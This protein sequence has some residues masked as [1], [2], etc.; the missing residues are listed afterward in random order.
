MKIYIND[1]PFD[2]SPYDD[3][4]SILQRYSLKKG[5]TLPEYLRITDPDIIIKKGE[6]ITIKDVRDEFHWLTLNDLLDAG[7][8]DDIERLYPYLEKKYISIL[9][10]LRKY[11]NISNED[12]K[13]NLSILKKIDELVFFS[14]TE[15][16]RFLR[17][18][19]SYTEK[20]LEEIRNKVKERNEIDLLFSKTNPAPI[21]DFN[22]KEIDVLYVLEIAQGISLE[23]I[24]DIINVSK[25]IPF[26]YLY[27]N[28]VEQGRKEW[29]K[30]YEHFDPPMYMIQPEQS[31]DVNGIYF[32]ILT[33]SKEG[34]EQFNSDCVWYEN[35]NIIISFTLD[36]N[37]KESTIKKIFFDSLGDRLKYK[38]TQEK[39]IGVKGT[40]I[41]EDLSFNRAILADMISNSSIFSYFFFFNENPP[42]SKGKYKTAITKERFMFHYDP[43]QTG[44]SPRALSIVV[45]P[46][47]FEETGEGWI[48][49]R[50]RK[51]LSRHQVEIFQYVFSRLLRIYFN[52]CKTVISEYANILPN[53]RNLFNK[54]SKKSKP[55]SKKIDKKSGKRL[56]ELKTTR[57]G[58]FRPGYASLCQP[59][60][61]QPY[62]LKDKDVESFRKEYGDHKLMEFEDPTT[63]KKDWYACEPREFGEPKK[64]IYPGLRKNTKGSGKYKSEVSFVP[65]CF[66]ED[67]YTKPAAELRRRMEKSIQEDNIEKMESMGE[68]GHILSSNKSVPHGRFGKIPYYLTSIVKNAGYKNVEKGKQSI[69]PIFRY[70]VMDSTSSFLHCMEKAFNPRYSSVDQKGKINIV[71][72][73]REGLSN[74]N[75]AVAAQELFGYSDEN[76]KDILLDENQYI[77]PSYFI[78]LVELKYDCN[79][80]IYKMS[81]EEPCGS[82]VIPRFS[83][84]Y[85]PRDI[86][87]NRRSVFIIKKSTERFH[88]FQ[89]EILVKYETG[90]KR[91]KRFSFV[92]Q[93]DPIVNQAIQVFYEANTISS[94]TPK[95]FSYYSPIQLTGKLFDK[96][97]SQYI[98]DTGKTRMLVY[99]NGLCLMTS[100]L[101]PLDKPIDKNINPVDT[102]TAIDFIES[103]GLCITMQDGDVY[104]KKIQGLWVEPRHTKNIGISYGYIPVI[105]ENALKKTKSNSNLVCSQDT[106]NTYI[107]FTPVFLNDPLRTDDESELQ[108]YRRTRKIAEFLKE[109]T[110]FQYSL[111]PKGFGKDTF[112]VNPKHEYNIQSLNKR[113]IEGTPV[114]YQKGKLI[115]PSD[116]VRNHLINYLRVQLINNYSEVMSYSERVIVKNY[117]RTLSDFR[118]VPNQFVFIDER[119]LL[120]WKYDKGQNMNRGL[121]SSSTKSGWEP[122][123]Y[124]NYNIERGRL[125]IIQNVRDGTLE[126]ALGVGENWE[127]NRINSGYEYNKLIDPESIS[128]VVYTEEGKKKEIKN[129]ENSLEIKVM[130]YYDD[131]YA[132]LLFF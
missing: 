27:R 45:T 113:L 86:A 17:D 55:I 56:I 43:Q 78:S 40:F 76:I 32:K 11:K 125:S 44:P 107:D 79:I 22:L 63:N 73:V 60:S 16:E 110:L 47:I 93:N 67:Q 98:D 115:V 48:E 26:I 46:Q 114:M 28:G 14:T 10:L 3:Y 13:N 75:F 36:N 51:A 127:E 129:K 15:I 58:V 81:D 6:R 97:K 83:Q 41:V 96:V 100:P 62:L 102:N 85:L 72:K 117:Y 132:S 53:A 59:M 109:Y 77:D 89:C 112:I 18:Y 39:Q 70:G 9:V 104:D 131:T 82:I 87:E 50:V 33:S 105:V 2:A 61:S 90:T 37:L 71:K 49:V 92:F 35:N 66:G 74:M 123:F 124:R 119:S 120:M 101:P 122:Y 23:N 31:H 108:K 68:M 4:I 94:V 80:F 103:N 21:G 29:Y 12:I 38:I 24:F 99:E 130:K 34:Q 128:Y 111:D 5:D 1:K 65:C 126:R 8:I 42:D 25:N 54:Y 7:V 121:I 91:N 64:D 116:K 88:E 57:P 69:L 84:A 106:K 95:S 19:P 30:V 20:R 118:K 52:D